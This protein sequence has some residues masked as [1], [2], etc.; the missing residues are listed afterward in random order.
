VDLRPTEAELLQSFKRK[1]RYNIRLAA[2]N[3]VVVRE[4]DVDDDSIQIMFGLMAQTQARAGF[5]L[6]SR[7]YCESYWRLHDQRGQGRFFFAYLGDEVLAGVFATY[8]GKRAWYKDGGSTREHSTLKGPYLLQWEVM[9]WLRR[10]GIQSYD[11]YAVPPA[12]LLESQHPLFGLYLFKSRFCDTITEFIGTWELPLRKRR[13]G[14][15]D[16]VG[17]RFLKGRRDV[18]Y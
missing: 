12:H 2:R 5:R 4:V 13:V 14:A 11:L 9:R 18:F 17:N 10:R 1:A 16:I 15:W 3:G 6:R 8:V 7:E